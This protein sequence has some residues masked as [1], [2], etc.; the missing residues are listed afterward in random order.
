MKKLALA[1]FSS[2]VAFAWIACID[3]SD[4]KADADAATPAAPLGLVTPDAGEEA[5]VAQPDA[6]NACS[7]RSYR[8]GAPGAV[9]CPG[10]LSC[11]C[12]ANE[13]CCLT[14]LDAV[15]GACSSLDACRSLAIQCDGPE[16]CDGGVCCLE[17]RTGGGASC[18]SGASCSA[19]QWLCRN[20]ADCAGSPMGPRCSP[21]DLGTPGVDDV[22]LDGI[23]GVCGK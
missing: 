19:G 17:D 10:T 14:K 21:I 18:K 1:I 7:A 6:A 4:P 8:G 9:V 12:G 15:G 22:G 13:V 5:A 20:D 16:D 23:V 2:A 11:E 3:Y